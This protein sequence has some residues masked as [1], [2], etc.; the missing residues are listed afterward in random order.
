MGKDASKRSKSSTVN[1]KFHKGGKKVSKSGA[2]TNPD[3]K[4]TA[5]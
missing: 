5:K 3:R 4:L 2:S 1:K